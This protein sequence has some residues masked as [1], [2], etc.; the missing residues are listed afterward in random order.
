[1]S[2]QGRM[3]GGIIDAHLHVWQ[4]ATGDYVWN[5]P[6]LGVVHSD[7]GSSDAVAALSTSRVSFAILVQAA[8]TVGDSERM[9]QIAESEHWVAGVVASV[10]LLH[11]ERADEMLDG[12]SGRPVVGVRQLVHD[13]PDANLLDSASV[14]ETGRLL[15]KRGLPLDIPDAWPRLWPAVTRLA[16]DIPELSIVIDH[17]GKPELGRVARSIADREDQ[18]QRWEHDLLALA[19]FPNVTAKLSG[20]G[21]F[22]AD[23][24]AISAKAVEPFVQTALA[25]FG[26]DRLMFGSDWPMSLPG[27]SYAEV[28]EATVTALRSLSETENRSV[29]GGTTS[30]VYGLSD[31]SLTGTV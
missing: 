3:D 19:A 31:R 9:L 18:T 12:W 11:P 5:T 13:S 7:F 28:T 30:R 21:A 29:L 10:P 8:D 14:R 24:Q 6:A 4:L 15:A 23:G 25:T 2:A 27:G 22:L 17:L 16:R 20:L 1:M 26:P